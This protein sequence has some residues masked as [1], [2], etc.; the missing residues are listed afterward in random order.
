MYMDILYIYIF[1]YL[2]SLVSDCRSGCYPHSDGG[3][4]CTSAQRQGACGE[5]AILSNM[6]V[7]EMYSSSC[8]RA[9]A[10]LDIPDCK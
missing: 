6:D 1:I 9:C 2:Y 4:V 7:T 3:V 8:A 5:N 10:A